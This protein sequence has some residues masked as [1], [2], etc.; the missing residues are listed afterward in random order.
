M[1]TLINCQNK[2]FI[3]TSHGSG[4]W[5][6]AGRNRRSAE[7]RTAQHGARSAAA[8]TMARNEYYV[9]TIDR[10]GHLQDKLI[11]GAVNESE[12]QDVAAQGPTK[13]HD[14]PT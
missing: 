2:I 12:R 8:T 5:L 14:T 3:G 6:T 1:Y 4:S 7:R 9:F 10:Q 11:Y 13:V